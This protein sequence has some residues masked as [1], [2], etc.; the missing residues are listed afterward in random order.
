MK[1]DTI[2]L[3]ADNTLLD[4]DKT[5]QTALKN[6]LLQHQYP[7]NRQIVQLYADINDALWRQFEAGEISQETVV[8]RRFQ[9]LFDAL[10]IPGNGIAFEKEY[11]NA[12]GEGSFLIPH[13]YSVCE[14]LSGICNLYIVT[15]GVAKTQYKRLKASGLFPFFLDIFISEE[16]GYRK[17]QK[18]FFNAVF[19]KISEKQ[20]F[21]PAK[22]L[23][24]G[25]SLTSDIQGGRNAGIDT[26][27]FAL[28]PKEQ[29]LATYEINRLP[30]LIKIVTGA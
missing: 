10:Q 11:Q 25:D 18:E 1:Y 21:I 14:M 24:V 9:L 22:T 8:N 3:D 6:T 7:Y 19:Q 26:C 5:E 20:S 27:Y 30:E 13:A 4:F 23:M 12:L 17:P 16:I 28:H 29:T 2:L 15:N